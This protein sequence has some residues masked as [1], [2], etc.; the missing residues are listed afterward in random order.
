LRTSVIQKLH[1]R[2][3]GDVISEETIRQDIRQVRPVLRLI[4]KGIIPRS[5]RPE[6]QPISDKTLQEMEAGRKAVARAA[7]RQQIIEALRQRVR[8]LRNS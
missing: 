7:K 1:L 6:K 5:G 4:Q 8:N 3:D 2:D